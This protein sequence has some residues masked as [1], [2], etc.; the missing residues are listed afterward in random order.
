MI[1]Y[2]WRDGAIGVARRLPD[3]AI[4]LARGGEAAI[5]AL[6]RELPQP[7]EK[8]ASRRLLPDVARERDDMRAGALLLHWIA[9]LS[10]TT[11]GRHAT[12]NRTLDPR[13]V[14]QP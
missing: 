1:L 8:G 5:H 10:A 14:G 6:L 2:C 9:R 13:F 12:F 7:E 4:E 11:G 3:G